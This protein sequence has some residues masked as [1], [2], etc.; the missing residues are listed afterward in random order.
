M[1]NIDLICV[2]KLN[3]KDFAE[4]VA[5]S[6][7]YTH[8]ERGR[9]HF[10]P[11]RG[12][13]V[14]DAAAV[15]RERFG[16]RAACAPVS[17]THLDVYKRPALCTALWHCLC[18]ACR[19]GRVACKLSGLLCGAQKI[20]ADGKCSG[21]SMILCS[22]G[23][24]GGLLGKVQVAFPSGGAFLMNTALRRKKAKGCCTGR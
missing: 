4:G 10:H 22:A 20:V 1:Q 23:A 2:G 13:V 8:L 21:T 3:A 18:L 15:L 19:P 9:F 14:S 5:E 12:G 24:G 7:S 6:V 17:Y 16:M 11:R